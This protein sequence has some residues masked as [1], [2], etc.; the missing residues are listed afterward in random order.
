[1][2]HAKDG[3]KFM[4][5][6]TKATTHTIG[7]KPYSMAQ[8]RQMTLESRRKAKHRTKRLP[9]AVSVACEPKS[10]VTISMEDGCRVFIP[11]S[12]FHEL[13]GASD[14]ELR[15]VILRFNGLSIEWPRLDMTFAICERVAELF[16]L[17]VLVKDE[18]GR[19]GGQSTSPAKAAAARANGRK[20]G[21]PRKTTTAVRA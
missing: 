6:I 9:R 7:V 5:K 18:F 14:G 17:R 4:A 19:R 16:G 1:M 8:L 12:E 21:R 11:M 15:D 2:P 3:G 20:G 13:R 10:G